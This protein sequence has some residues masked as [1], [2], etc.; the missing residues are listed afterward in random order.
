MTHR[1][2][3]MLRATYISFAVVSMTIH[4]AP[5]ASRNND[6]LPTPRTFWIPPE[7]ATK[8][9]YQLL[10]PS[11]E[12]TMQA[13][14]D[15]ASQI[16]A[17]GQHFYFADDSIS[18]Q[19]NLGVPTPALHGRYSILEFL[20][21]VTLGKCRMRWAEGEAT[22]HFAWFPPSWQYPE[23]V[24]DDTRAAPGASSL[25]QGEANLTNGSATGRVTSE[26]R[27]NNGNAEL[28]VINQQQASRNPCVCE[29]IR[30]VI[31]PYDYRTGR[32]TE[33]DGSLLGNVEACG[34][35]IV[36]RGERH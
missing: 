25:S 17:Q 27:R 13:L 3:I 34:V 32:C 33:L 16:R 15:A 14:Q 26:R 7:W 2:L 12:G 11:H 5:T 1:L 4:A 35:G 36:I 9:K 6:Y 8:E 24:S 23:N 20:M 10:V 18:P 29:E 31:G 19:C 21:A 28:S 22:N 30:D